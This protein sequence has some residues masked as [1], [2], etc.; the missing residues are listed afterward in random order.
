MTVATKMGRRV[1]LDPALYTLAS[2]QP[3][4]YGCS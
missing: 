3:E 1:A 4:L 2:F